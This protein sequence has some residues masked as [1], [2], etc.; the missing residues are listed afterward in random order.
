MII[1]SDVWGPSKVITLGGS[2]WFVTF[3][4][5]CSRMT[6]VCLLKTKGEVNSLFQKF[7]EMIRTRYKAQVQV[8]CSDNS[9]E[10]HSSEPQQH[11]EEHG[12]IHQTTCSNT[13]KQNGLSEWKNRHLLGVVHASI[14]K[15]HMSLSYWVEALAF[16]VYLINR[17]LPASSTFGHHFKLLLKQLLLQLSQTY[18]FTSLVV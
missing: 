10:Y 14:I 1:H 5:N 9:G 13:P 11:L 3:I 8:I 4:D 16:A 2:H 18:L 17:Y 12:A 7:H 6:W 15:A